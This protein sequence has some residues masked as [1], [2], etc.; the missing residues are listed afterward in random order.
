MRTAGA[1]PYAYKCTP[2]HMARELMTIYE[3]KLEPGQED[4]EINVAVASRI[5]AWRVFG[6]L[7][8]YALHDET[9]AIQLQFDKKRLG[10][11]DED[12]F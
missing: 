5:M 7:A 9:G 8:F 2:S 12:S 1:Q 3:S 6:K 4:N 10:E 11:I